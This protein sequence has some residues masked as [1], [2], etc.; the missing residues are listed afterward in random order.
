MPATTFTHIIAPKI[1]KQYRKKCAYAF[2][3]ACCQECGLY[4][5]ATGNLTN[6]VCYLGPLTKTKR[7][8]DMSGLVSAKRLKIEP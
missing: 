4:L 6:E 8:F 5:M 1:A 3:G 2:R 7:A